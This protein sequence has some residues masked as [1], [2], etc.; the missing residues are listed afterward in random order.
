[1]ERN[2]NM[3]NF[4]YFGLTRLLFVLVVI[5]INVSIA[6]MPE[7]PTYKQL[8]MDARIIVKAEPMEFYYVEPPTGNYIFQIVTFDVK[9]V[10]KGKIYQEF[11]CKDGLTEEDEAIIWDFNIPEENKTHLYNQRIYVIVALR[12]TSYGKL[13]PKYKKATD[14]ILYLGHRA[15]QNLYCRSN[16]DDIWPEHKWTPRIHKKLMKLKKAHK[17]DSDAEC[18]KSDDDSGGD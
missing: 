2:R 18:D 1:M 8:V 12:T 15:A 7:K 14:Y 17:K 11:Y 16:L 9:H 13:P 4:G 5:G 10:Y 3:K 6:E